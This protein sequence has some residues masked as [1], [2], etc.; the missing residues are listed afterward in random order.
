V[1]DQRRKDDA[2]SAPHRSCRCR[3]PTIRSETKKDQCTKPQHI[4][5]KVAYQVET[6]C[7]V[8][9]FVR[10]W[11]EESVFCVAKISLFIAVRHKL[12]SVCRHGY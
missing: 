8:S 10:L 7:C 2:V 3:R 5:E 12:M 11:L 6:Y 4:R 1:D 9:F